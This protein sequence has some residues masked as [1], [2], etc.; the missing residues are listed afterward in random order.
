M[1][2]T[3]MTGGLTGTPKRLLDYPALEHYLSIGRTRCYE[4]VGAGEI[5]KIKIGVRTLF[6]IRDVDAYIDRVK[7]AS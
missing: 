2:K 1:T 6:D 5:P 3:D 4:L 7:K